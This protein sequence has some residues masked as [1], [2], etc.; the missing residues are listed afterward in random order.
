[1]AKFNIR[2]TKYFHDYYSRLKNIAVTRY[3]W[4]GLPSSCNA[5]FLEDVLFHYGI[6]ILVKD[7]DTDY[8]TLKCVPSGELNV[9]NEPVSYNAFSTG[10]SKDYRAEECVIIRNNPL[11][12][13]TESSI[14]IYAERLALLDIVWELNI[15]AQ[16][17]PV[18]IKTDEKTRTSMLALYNQ[19]EGDKPF[20]VVS[21]SMTDKP[22]EVLKTD[23]PFTADK[24]R[25]EKRNV[26]NE[27]LEFLGINT[28]PSDKKKE[29]LVV[30]EVESNNEQI[31]S[32]DNT[33]LKCRKESCEKASEIFGLNISVEVDVEKEENQK[34]GVV[35]G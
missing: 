21:K 8:L 20:I 5:R 23:A 28:N 12:K 9:Y 17:N 10:Y 11:E 33:M 26:W 29:R 13:S 35:N 2:R 7:E 6:A 27:A 19:Y 24:I 18:L 31:E 1:M 30:N 25:E 3:K 4:T 32:Q 34:E 16:K 22:I 14:I 15:N